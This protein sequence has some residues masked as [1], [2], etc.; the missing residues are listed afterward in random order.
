MNNLMKSILAGSFVVAGFIGCDLVNPTDTPTC[1]FNDMSIP[2][3]VTTGGG[4]VQVNGELKGSEDITDVAVAVLNSSG[5]AA[6]GFTTPYDAVVKE[7]L[8]L[9]NDLHLKI[10]AASSVTAGTYKLKITATVGG[11]EFSTEISFTVKTGS[12]GIALTEKTN[13]I[14]SNIFGPDQGAFNLVD[15][16]RVSA[17]SAST[18][19]DLLDLSLVGEGFKGELGSD[20]GSTF[21]VADAAD[22]TNATDVSV[23]ALAGTATATKVAV[24][25]VGTVFAVKLGNS[26]GYA[27]VKITSYDETAGG[28]TG[29]NKGEVEFSYKFTN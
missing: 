15:G 20:N 18:T 27:I 11:T 26:R 3:D 23:K 28:S 10:S 6:S 16:E 13:G 1:D 5:S 12:T 19:K 24:S 29:D 2:S 8:D 4:A 9:E 14:I 25:T 17:S 21:V 22:Y 7:K